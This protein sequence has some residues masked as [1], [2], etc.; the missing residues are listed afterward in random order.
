[1]PLGSSVA[2]VTT[3]DACKDVCVAMDNAV[4]EAV[5]FQSKTSKC[6]RKTNI[7]LHRCVKDADFVLYLRTDPNRP[8]SAPYVLPDTMTSKSCSAAM[9]RRD[10]KFYSIWA[11]RGWSVRRPGEEAC[12]GNGNWFDWVARTE[13]CRQNWGRNL[14]APTVFGFK[15]SM[16]GYCNDATGDGW[17]YNGG[18]EWACGRA[19]LNI[20]RTG[21]W[22]MCR[23]AEW[24]ICIIKNDGAGGDGTIIFSFAPSLLDMTDYSRYVGG[25]YSENDIYYLEVCTLNEMCLNY[26]EIFNAKVGDPFVCQFDPVRWKAYG[27][28]MKKLG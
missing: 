6:F 9:R 23:N 20:L 27:E 7:D 10:H 8:P 16:E 18:L 19:N 28:D 11:E 5:L 2:G 25:G 22:N 13:N 15:E 24:M 26:E 3:L 1:M 14:V 4:C 12:W 17:H 21:Q